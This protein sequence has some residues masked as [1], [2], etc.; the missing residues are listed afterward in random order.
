[1]S[2]ALDRRADGVDEDVGVR[3]H[4]QGLNGAQQPH[5]FRE[6]LD[7][8]RRL[9][10]LRRALFVHV[11]MVGTMRQGHGGDDAPIR[12]IQQNIIYRPCPYINT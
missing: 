10:R 1:M 4:V 6:Q 8:A 2:D 3:R 9:C 11:G 7:G 5:R 12:T